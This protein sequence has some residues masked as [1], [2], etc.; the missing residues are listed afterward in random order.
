MKH[1][2]ATYLEVLRAL[3]VWGK[4]YVGLFFAEID[5]G[6]DDEYETISKPHTPIAF[7]I[8]CTEKK[9]YKGR[10][11]RIILITGKSLDRFKGKL[12]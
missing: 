7:A 2:V 10:I 1:I 4:T 8:T 6:S 3:F 5:R 12:K 9:P 11:F